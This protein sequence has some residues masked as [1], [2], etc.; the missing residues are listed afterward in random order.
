MAV[1][2]NDIQEVKGIKVLHIRG[3]KTKNADRL[4]PIP[5]DFLAYVE[6][7][8]P[9]GFDL[10][11]CK[12]TGDLHNENTYR[13]LLKSLRR[14][15]NIAMGARIYRN[16]L[17][18]PL[19]LAKDFTPYMLRHTYCTDL[20]K[21][22]VPLGIAKDYMGHST[23]ELTA[24]IYSHCDDDTLLAGASYLGITPEGV[25]GGVSLK[26]CKRVQNE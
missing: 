21:A 14:E 1:R 20:K 16:K 23:I 25:S 12:S 6:K 24:N 13:A 2:A 8:S 17:I 15:M 7:V 10:F 22:G 18:E 5:L 9:G 3:T 26:G 11:S 4:V 19:P